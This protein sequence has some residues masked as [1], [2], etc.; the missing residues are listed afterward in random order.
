MRS[1]HKPNPDRRVR[2]SN[3][4]RVSVEG[5]KTGWSRPRCADRA[6]GRYTIPLAPIAIPPQLRTAIP[7]SRPPET[8][9]DSCVEQND[10]NDKAFTEQSG[11]SASMS[12]LIRPMCLI[13]TYTQR[14]PQRHP[15]RSQ[16]TL[17]PRPRSPTLDVTIL[18]HPRH[19]YPLCPG[20]PLS[21]PCVASQILDSPTSPIES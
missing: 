19:V 2:P 4:S 14:F 1:D 21:L 9:K 13:P 3:L 20:P 18:L 5:N 6:C 15:Q 17:Y 7:L 8:S 10:E 11:S 12:T 16:A